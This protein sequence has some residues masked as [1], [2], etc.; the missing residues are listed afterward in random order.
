METTL[1]RPASATIPRRRFS[2]DELVAME[3]AGVFGLDEK[4]EL[5]DGDIVPMNAQNMPHMLWK[6]RLDRWFQRRLPDTL[7]LVCEGTLRL[8]DRPRASAFE[9]DLVI[10]EPAPDATAIRPPMVR[11]AIEVADASRERDLDVKAP[12]YGASGVVELWVVDL[13]RRATVIHRQPSPTGY[14]D[15]APVAFAEAVAPLFDPALAITLA[16][17]DPAGA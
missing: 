1:Q 10:F 6:S 12:I 13:K 17:L 15:V 11:L 7:A 14:L 8:R 3:A 5:I 9:T 16:E 4:V 2:F